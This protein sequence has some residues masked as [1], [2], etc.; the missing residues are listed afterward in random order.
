MFR[1]GPLFK[2]LCTAEGTLDNPRNIPHVLE[3]RFCKIAGEGITNC[4]CF[5]LGKAYKLVKLMLAPLERAGYTAPERRTQLIPDLRY[6]SPM[7]R[8]SLRP[9]IAHAYLGD[10]I[11]SSI[12]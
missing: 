3:A 8:T 11:N 9:A 1:L 5:V 6:A 12:S 4:I 2:F 10:V 7:S